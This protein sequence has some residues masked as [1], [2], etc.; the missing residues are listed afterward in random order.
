[1]TMVVVMPAKCEPGHN[2]CATLHVSRAFVVKMRDRCP[3]VRRDDG[4]SDGRGPSSQSDSHAFE[5]GDIC[6][7]QRHLHIGECDC[8][9]LMD[10][11]FS[12]CP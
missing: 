4:E 5:R 2:A 11:P 8:L 9:G 12:K 10:Y 1:M 7:N 6:D 3:R